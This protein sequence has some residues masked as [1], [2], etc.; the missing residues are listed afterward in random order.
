L[1]GFARSRTIE[2]LGGLAI[3]GARECFGAHVACTILLDSST[4]IRGRTL[5]GLRDAEF[6]EWDREWRSQDGVFPIALRHATPVHTGQ[7]FRDEQWCA[8]PQYREF[9]RRFRI[10]RYLAAPIFGSRGHLAG[11]LTMCRR[12]QDR[13]FDERVTTTVSMFTGFLSASFAR[14]AEAHRTQ[15]T[16]AVDRLAPRELEVARLAAAGRNNLE[17]A[18]ELGLARETVKQTLRRVYAKLG[19]RGRAPMA[20]QLAAFERTCR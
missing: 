8:Q 10:E 2:E 4:T 11:M 15:A 5:Y 17:I 7:L 18:L 16:T 19:V 20:A 6:D 13:P 1:P 14:I 9:G 3:D 12:A